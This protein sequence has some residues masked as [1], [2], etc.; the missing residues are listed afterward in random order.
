M[1]VWSSGLS[2]GLATAVD[3]GLKQGVQTTTGRGHAVLQ[4]NS[5][6]IWVEEES[7]P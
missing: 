3:E 2:L 5:T 1:V 4:V 7:P 6:V